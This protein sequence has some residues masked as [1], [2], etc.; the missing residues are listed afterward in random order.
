MGKPG[1]LTLAALLWAWSLSAGTP[2]VAQFSE[3]WAPG[4]VVAGE[5]CGIFARWS[6]RTAVSGF[7]IELPSGWVLTRAV[8]LR[9]GYLQIPFEIQQQQTGQYRIT[10]AQPLR[11]S[12]ELALHAL[13]HGS[14]QS[15]AWSIMPVLAAGQHAPSQARITRQVQQNPVPLHLSNRAL[16]LQRSGSPLVLDQKHL[17]AI[18]RSA[19]FTVEAWIKTTA[20]TR[21]VLST[22]NGIN[23]SD[24]PL[25][26]IVDTYGRIRSYH[27]QGSHHVS[28]ASHRPVADGQWHHVA[29][30]H[31]PDDRSTRL[32][33]DGEPADSVYDAAIRGAD[34][35]RHLAV[36]HRLEA[37]TKRNA[38]IPRFEGDIDE[39]RVWAVARSRHDIRTSMRQSLAS[40]E[41]VAV[42]SF[43]RPERSPLILHRASGSTA[44]WTELTFLA[45]AQHFRGE[46]TPLGVR[47]LWNASRG[48]QPTYVIERSLNG[49]DFETVEIVADAEEDHFTFID[50]SVAS[51]MVYYRLRQQYAN[52]QEQY[53][54]TIKLGLAT[55]ADTE[56]TATILGNYPNPFNPATTISYEL[57]TEQS[58]RLSVWDISG[59][60]VETLVSQSQKPGIWHV[61]FNG[62]ELPSGTY[63]V[64]L[65]GQDG[66][67]QTRKILL[68]K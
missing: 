10:V 56:P 7:L 13:T 42:L 54:G 23:E 46:V 41:D 49:R 4:E 29:L 36:G 3:V 65:A 38:T 17:P 59:Q 44:A 53:S 26:L 18:Q 60:L 24:Y 39:I 68:M 12:F 9:H 64:R 67:A 50:E 31:N 2:A 25:E 32:Y 47:L 37:G 33:L 20:R 6:G 21:I 57:T 14:S 40:R 35:R 63:F 27:K 15:T 55:G 22:W 58:V 16:R 1:S 66:R 34:G 19:P 11:G 28:I 48:L 51:P 30:V 43:D 5:V 8:A 52:G 61:G 62:A 45:P